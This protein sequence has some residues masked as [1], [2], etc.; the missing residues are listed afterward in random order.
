MRSRCSQMRGFTL[1]EMMV[2]L[3]IALIMMV[4]I[5]PVFQVTTRTVQTVERKLAIYEAA[6]NILDIID[7]EVRMAVINER[8]NTFSIKSITYTDT[9][10]NDKVSRP[11]TD[12]PA[13]G[14]WD[15]LAYRQSRR[16]GDSITYVK[17]QGGA[18]RWADNLLMPGSQAF[19]LS[20]P[21]AFLTTPEA[22]KTTIRSS[23]NF[24]NDF[25]GNTMGFYYAPKRPIQLNDV[26]K[27]KCE[28]DNTAIT[29]EWMAG[30]PGTMWDPVFGDLNPGFE[31]K[32]MGTNWPSDPH[33]ESMGI[34]GTDIHYQIMRTFGAINLMDIDIAYWDAK[35]RQF[36]DPPDNTLLALA[37]A[38]RAVRLTITV[39]DKERRGTATLSR[40]IQMPVGQGICDDETDT[41][42]GPGVRQITRSAFDNTRMDIDIQ[43]FNRP[44]DLKTL[45][46]DLFN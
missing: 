29:A 3:A 38:P 9:D 11:G 35:A 39:C 27:I 19:P 12:S 36:K 2:V 41:A 8:G 1:L 18:F 16:E 31:H 45:E 15:P 22:W 46:V 17:M 23:L 20:Y 37:P 13:T 5:L 21:E 40:V 6:R 7:Y 42:G 24:P 14:K 25:G 30:S 26:G 43:P 28:V 10:A 33:K 32:M 4:M 44:K 34:S